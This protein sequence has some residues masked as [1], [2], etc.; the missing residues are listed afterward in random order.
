LDISLSSPI[1]T[2]GEEVTLTVTYDRK[3]PMTLP[4]KLYT[5]PITAAGGG[6]AG[7]TSVHLFVG[8]ARVYFPTLLQNINF[9]SANVMWKILP[10]ASFCWLP[11]QHEPP[12]GRNIVK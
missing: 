10:L 7:A 11:V 6:F 5:V 9:S 1:L 2:A 3:E 12:P 4:A 8:G